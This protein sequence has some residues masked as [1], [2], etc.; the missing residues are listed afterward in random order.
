MESGTSRGSRPYGGPRDLGRSVSHLCRNFVA[1]S[2]LGK[3]LVKTARRKR[4]L[5]VID[6]RASGVTIPALPVTI[7][8]RPHLHPIDYPPEL[9][10][11][12]IFRSK[13][14][15]WNRSADVELHSG[16]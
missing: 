7:R 15:G 6:S 3:Q 13:S 11:R 12:Q 5:L 14:G 1:C 4:G 9:L 10:G 8:T 16:K 2:V